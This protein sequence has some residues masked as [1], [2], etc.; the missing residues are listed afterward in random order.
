MSASENCV[1]RAATSDDVVIHEDVTV[2]NRAG[3]LQKSVFPA[4]LAKDAS[5]KGKLRFS[6]SRPSSSA[7]PKGAKPR[8]GGAKAAERR[9]LDIAHASRQEGSR[10]PPHFPGPSARLFSL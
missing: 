2:E 9:R 5:P 8:G 7:R 1:D 6:S 3:K 10:C 4:E